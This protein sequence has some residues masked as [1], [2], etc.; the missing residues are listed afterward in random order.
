VGL[1]WLARAGRQPLRARARKGAML[2]RRLTSL[3]RATSLLVCV[4]LLADPGLAAGAPSA[5][6]RPTPPSAG[7]PSADRLPPPLLAR[8]PT[9]WPDPAARA[10][11]PVVEPSPDPVLPGRLGRPPAASERW[12]DLGP[13]PPHAWPA[14]AGGVAPLLAI[15]PSLDLLSLLEWIAP[16]R[17]AFAQGSAGG[18]ALDAGWQLVSIP[19]VPVDTAPAAVLASLGDG[20]EIVRAHDGCDAL[21]ARVY[22]PTAT[23]N[24]DDPS[25]MDDFGGGPAP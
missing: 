3:Y 15:A 5:P 16:A 19:V 23:A 18:I 25:V 8:S 11:P 4:A 20:Y 22:D 17:T 14:G 6:G 7:Q 1:G 9:G 21:P 12:P 10:G 24:A 2:G 13:R